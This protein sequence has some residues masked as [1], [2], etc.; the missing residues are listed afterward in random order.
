MPHN[1][2]RSANTLTCW[3]PDSTARC[4]KALG[5]VRS[6]EAVGTVESLTFARRSSQSAEQAPHGKTISRS[7]VRAKQHVVR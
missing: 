5:T 6:G 4:R 7:P 2:N 1:H 3:S